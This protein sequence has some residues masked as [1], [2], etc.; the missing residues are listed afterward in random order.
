MKMKIILESFRRFTEQKDKLYLPPDYDKEVAATKQK[1]FGRDLEKNPAIKS[2]RQYIKTKDEDELNYLDFEF[3]ESGYRFLG[4]G[5]FRAV[6][7][8]PRNDELVLK[9]VN[10]SSLTSRLEVG[11]K[12]NKADAAAS[13][14]TSS[15]YVVK[16]FASAEDFLW[17][18]C[19]KVVP[20]ETWGG[21][22]SFFPTWNKLITTKGIKGSRLE[23]HSSGL[24]YLFNV[25]IDKSAT[26]EGV[27]NLLSNK[28]GVD[29]SIPDVIKAVDIMVNKSEFAQIRD[30]LAQFGS[31]SSDIRPNNVGWT[32]REGKKQF[33][34]LDPGFEL[35][36]YGH[37]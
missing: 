25:L 27:L 35:Q 28:W 18:L 9:V 5:S 31:A 8:V 21:I 30:L 33:V 20:I 36:R 29:I 22:Q 11:L 15:P 2:M 10:D 3:R 7:S 34:I 13:F 1:Y 24:S 14:Q 6:Y 26:A 17:I 12:M 32:M 19:E 4:G 16:V 37:H 23:S